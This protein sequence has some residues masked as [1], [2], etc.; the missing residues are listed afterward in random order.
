MPLSA[1]TKIYAREKKMNAAVII[2]AAG[3]SSR[4]GGKEKKIFARVCNTP[5]FLRSINLFTQI[6]CVKQIILAISPQD[7]EKININWGANLAFDNIEICFGAADR[8]ETVLNSLSKIRSDIDLVAV[9]DAARCCTKI[10]WIKEAFEL[11]K[12]RDAAIL[13]CP[14]ISTIKQVENGKITATMDRT[15][16]Y[17]AQTPQIFK[18]EL[19]IKGYDNLKNIDQSKTPITDDCSLIEALGEEVSIVE[20][21]NSNIKITKSLDIALAEASVRS[22]EKVVAKPFHPFKDEIW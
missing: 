11:A 13:A 7:E 17:E 15:T 9:H 5:V 19:L 10:E 4:F 16:L 6:T 18:K 12:K 14:S 22:Q 21:D 2:C 8:S 1:S 3:A 20:T